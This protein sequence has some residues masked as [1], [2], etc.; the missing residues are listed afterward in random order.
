MGG[1]RNAPRRGAHDRFTTI[2]LTWVIVV[3][4]AVR[5]WGSLIITITISAFAL[6]ACAKFDETAASESTWE[7]APT[8]TP[9]R[10]PKPDDEGQPEPYA[11]PE[12]KPPSSAR[13]PPPDGCTDYD[14]AV[15]ATC[16]DTVSA[17]AAFPGGDR[18]AALAG[19]RRTGRVMHVVAEEKPRPWAKLKVS[20]VGGGGLTGLALS[21]SYNEDRLAFAYVTTATDNRVVRFAK[22][23]EPKPVL[24]GIPKG[25]SGNRGAL[26]LDGTGALLVATG[27]AGNPAAAQN[28][29]SLAGKVLRI[30]TSGGPADGNPAPGSRII[31]RGLHSPGGL[32][33]A[34]DGSRAWVTEQGGDGDALFLIEPGKAL[35]A[36]VW[37]WK[38]RPGVAGCLDSGSTVSVAMAKAGN[39][40][41]LQVDADG[42]VTGRPSVSFGE[43][44]NTYGRLSGLDILNAEVAVVGTVN[45]DGGKPV[46]SDDRVVLLS[47]KGGGAG[48]ID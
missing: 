8:L 33:A 14:R 24:T 47:I 36:P 32:C 38:Q 35:T 4:S 15:I 23:A 12:T 41:H 17:I 31:A 2:A 45:K 39:L 37:T 40:Q 34:V 20:P 19:E 30:D 16:L 18:P 25:R 6:P 21:P 48:G 10:G 11:A 43:K 26:T 1:Y 46:S 13:I 27:D 22:G 42:S 3:K 9:Q 5:L 28:P 29:R 44:G 7:N